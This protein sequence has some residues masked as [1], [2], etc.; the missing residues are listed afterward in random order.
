MTF[1]KTLVLPLLNELCKSTVKAHLHWFPALL[2]F[3]YM[4][5]YVS[6]KL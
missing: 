6:I 2:T 1:V 5:N 3:M 4:L